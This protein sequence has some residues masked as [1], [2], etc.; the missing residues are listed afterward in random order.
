MKQV[1]SL[2]ATGTH[3]VEGQVCSP[4]PLP[5]GHQSR[6]QRSRKQAA[7]AWEFSPQTAVKSKGKVTGGLCV[8][9]TALHTVLGI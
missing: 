2:H 4:S 3:V 6:P 7:W 5:C 1:F 9:A 8:P